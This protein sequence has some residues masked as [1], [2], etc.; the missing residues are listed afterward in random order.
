[1]C[2]K[3]SQDEE[4]RE[5]IDHVSRFELAVDQYSKA[6]PCA[7]IDHIQD[8]VFSAIMRSIFSK[9]RMPDM[10]VGFRRTQMQD[11]LL[12][13]KWPCFS[14]LASYFKTFWISCAAW[15]DATPEN[16]MEAIGRCRV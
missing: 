3:A 10:F 8:A 9:V 15:I 1:M 13:D 2:W 11:T 5:N 16:G 12:S 4:I 6:L 14:L 7:L